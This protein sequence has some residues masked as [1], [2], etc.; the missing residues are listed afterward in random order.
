MLVTGNWMRAISPSRVAAF[1]V[2]MA[3]AS[4]AF[5]SDALRDRCHGLDHRDAGLAAQIVFGTLRYKGQLDHLILLSSRRSSEELDSVVQI[6][7]RASILQLRYLERVPAYAVV[8]D[9][10]E[11]IKSRKRAAAGLVN[12]VL[13]KVNRAPVEWP[14]EA[15]ELSL[16]QWLIDRWAAHFGRRQARAIAQASLN[17]PKQYIRIGPEADLPI[18]V[19]AEPTEVA[20]AFLLAS[21]AGPRGMRLQD[22]GSQTIVP[23]LDLLPGQTY[24][25]LCS[26]PGNK[27]LQALETPLKLAIACDF[28]ERRVRDMPPVCP[29]VVL[30]ATKPLPFNTLFDRILIDAPCSGTGTLARNPEIKWRLAEADLKRFRDRQ[31]AIL[32]Q[33]LQFLL[34]GGK[35]VYSTCSLEREENE[36]VIAEVLTRHGDV[37]KERELWR[38]PGRDE[39]D[40]FYA[41]LLTKNR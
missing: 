9:A 8:H 19:A 24:L 37:L 25:D 20:G 16:P 22:I 15:T 2:L 6:V 5:A 11:F 13:R 38:L 33:A 12:A 3:V 28:S 39:G 14:D 27:T 7:L 34:P 26:A 29:R 23:L 35:L 31:T 30:D 4:G 10:V 21:A 1:D 18:G 40:G 41:T 17:E 32:E 36:D